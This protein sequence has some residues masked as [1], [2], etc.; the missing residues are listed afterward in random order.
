MQWDWLSRPES[1]PYSEYDY[2][3]NKDI[4]LT[5]PILTDKWTVRRSSTTGKIEWGLLKCEKKKKMKGLGT[6][7]L[8]SHN[9]TLWVS[10]WRIVF[11]TMKSQGNS[12]YFASLS[13]KGYVSLY[14]MLFPCPLMAVNNQFFLFKRS[15]KS[16]KRPERPTDYKEFWKYEWSNLLNAKRMFIKNLHYI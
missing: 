7:F 6:W 16:P 8:L 14:G 12:R 13:A 2:S 9:M 5:S 1:S 15:A 10:Q 3:T 11:Y 4:K